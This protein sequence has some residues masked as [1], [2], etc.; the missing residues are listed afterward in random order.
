VPGCFFSKLVIPDFGGATTASTPYLA[1]VNARGLIVFETEDYGNVCCIP[2]GMSEVSTVKFDDGL[3]KGAKVKK[4]QEMGTFLYGGSSFAVIYQK[5]P[6]KLL[7]FVDAQGQ[8]YPQDPPPAASSSSTG[9]AVTNIGS[10][11][12]LWVDM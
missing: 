4:G 5:L 3:T 7:V 1:Q 6:K 11:I 10:Q 9:S 2:L 12:G 8:L